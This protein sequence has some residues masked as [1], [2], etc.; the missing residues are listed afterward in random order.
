MQDQE[1]GFRLDPLNSDSLNGPNREGSGRSCCILALKDDD[2]GMRGPGVNWSRA[3]ALLAVLRTALL[4]LAGFGSLAVA[5]F[6]F[7]PIV[8][9]VVLGV[10][11]LVI[12]FLTRPEGSPRA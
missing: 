5:G 7:S 3:V 8:G 2:R 6:L 10:A 1:E 4:T 9:C 11:L 12:E